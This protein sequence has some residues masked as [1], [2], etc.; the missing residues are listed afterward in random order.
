MV[1][2]FNFFDVLSINFIAI[3][4]LRN[5]NSLIL[6]SSV[7]ALNLIEEK[8]CFDGK[9]NSCTFFFCFAYFFSDLTV[10]PSLNLISYSLPSLKMLSISSSDS[11]FTTDTPTPCNPLKLCR[12]HDQTFRL[13]AIESLLLPQQTS[14]LLC[15]YPT[16]IPRPSSS[17]V[18]VLSELIE[19][20]FFTMSG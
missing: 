17:T 5:A 19:S 6:F 15:A 7:F 1:V 2:F 3:P 11:A 4:L 12:S 8:I 16:G 18:T 14:F 10:F 9:S 20:L 13:H